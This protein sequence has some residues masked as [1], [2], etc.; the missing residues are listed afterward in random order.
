METAIVKEQQDD[1]HSVIIAKSVDKTIH[2]M[3]L[4]YTRQED[5]EI[6]FKRIK[7]K[8]NQLWQWRLLPYLLWY[9]L[10]YSHRDPQ[11]KLV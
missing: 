11:L 8:T 4:V 2:D 1:A 7:L 5:S 9:M 6:Y 3:E 10:V